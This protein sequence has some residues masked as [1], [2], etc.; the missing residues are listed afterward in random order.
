MHNFTVNQLLLILLALGAG[1]FILRMFFLARPALTPEAARAALDAGTAV[2]V[3]V[4]DPSE[5]SHGV[6]RPAALLSLSDLRGSRTNWQPFLEK[7]RDKQILLYCASG[8]RSGMAA[9][10]LKREGFDAAN[11]G[12]FSA[13]ADSGLPVRRP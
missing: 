3:D 12:G 11:L 5:W 13:W 9:S 7:N 4:R 8:A 2:L 1:F 10:L 6:A